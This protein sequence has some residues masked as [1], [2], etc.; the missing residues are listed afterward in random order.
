VGKGEYPSDE[1]TREST[2]L[3]TNTDQKQNTVVTPTTW[4]LDIP[5]WL[6]DIATAVL[7]D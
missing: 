7:C 1:G 2:S 6:L 3:G 4:S 5:C